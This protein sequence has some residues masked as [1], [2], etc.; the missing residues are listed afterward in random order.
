MKFSP[1]SSLTSKAVVFS[2]PWANWRSRMM[3]ARGLRVSM[4]CEALEVGRAL[5]DA[6]LLE[7]LTALAAFPAVDLVDLVDSTAFFVL[8]VDISFL[9]L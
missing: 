9:Q 7:T 5:G 8:T 3:S 1:P 2:K 6:L 4:T